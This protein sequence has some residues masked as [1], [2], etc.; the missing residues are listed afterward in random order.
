MDELR[1][2]KRIRRK[3]DLTAADELVRHYYDE[4]HG[5]VRKQISNADVALDLTQEIFISMLR[6]IGHF[7]VK[8]SSGFRTWLYRIASNKVVDWYRSRSYRTMTQSVPFDDG[9]PMDET[10]FTQQFEDSDFTE[11]IC[12]YVG[13][14][15][16]DT[17][18][19]FRLYIFARYTFSEIANVLGLP[20]GSVKSK[21]YRLIRLL[22][23]EFADD[24]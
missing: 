5:F 4:I 9:K 14:L 22:R 19:I 17:Q 24:E 21:Y 18:R 12:D 16:P 10:D 2:I 1:L 15:P 11:R 23:K 13:G 3:S 6:T 20:E 7:D 8:R